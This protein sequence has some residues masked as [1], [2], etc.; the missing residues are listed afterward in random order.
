MGDRTVVRYTP[1]DTPIGELV[2]A[3]TDTHLVLLEYERRRMYEEQLSRVRNSLNCEF[4]KGE[5]PVFD[6]LRAQLD[7]YFAGK[8][9]EFTVPLHVPGTP[10]QTRVWHELQQ[11]PCGETTSYARLAE[12]IGNPGAIRAVG[13]ANGDNRIAIII[14]CHRVIGSNGQLVGYGGGLWRKKKLLEL[15]GIGLTLPLFEQ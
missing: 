15:E 11:I 9:K 12:R 13:R 8:R 7:E 4:E 5:S 3:A 1:V 2:A 6:L 10:F 14:P